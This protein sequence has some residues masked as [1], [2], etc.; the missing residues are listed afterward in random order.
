MHWKE[1][2][3][4][5]NNHFTYNGCM[6]F[7][8]KFIQALKF[9]EPGFAP[10]HD[11]TGWYHI[12]IQGMPFYTKRY[13][14]VFG[15]YA[16]RAS[17]IEHGMWFHIDKHG[18]R[19][20]SQN[21]AFTGNF[22][23]GRCVVR[24]EH[25]YYFHI[26]LHGERVYQENYRYVGDYK[27]GYACVQLLSGKFKH[28]DMHGKFIYIAE[29]D[30]LGVF[31]KNFAT[32]KDERGWFHIDEYGKQCYEMCYNMI[33]PFYNGQARVQRHDSTFLLIDETGMEIRQL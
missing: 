12:D 32:A 23:K 20:Y 33:E 9:H 31:H 22:Q 10:V 5:D 15:Y 30:D 17:V 4:T 19:V 1:I 11:K 21:Y 28:I 8:K 6:L 24:N 18:K 29:F 26:D 14:C 25:G 27:D 16:M 2:Q 13:E 7:D 3:L